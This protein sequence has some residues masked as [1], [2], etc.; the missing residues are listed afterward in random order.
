MSARALA[1][2]MAASMGIELHAPVFGE[3]EALCVALD[4]F[5]EQGRR[6]PLP[7]T[8][9][10]SECRGKLAIVD[11]AGCVRLRKLS[12]GQRRLGWSWAPHVYDPL[13]KCTPAFRGSFGYPRFIEEHGGT[14]ELDA[15]A[16]RGW[17]RAW[18]DGWPRD[19]RYRPA[20]AGVGLCYDPTPQ[21]YNRVVGAIRQRLQS[22]ELVWPDDITRTWIN[23]PPS[24]QMEL[25]KSHR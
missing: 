1:D 16:R 10:F 14:E 7:R 19:T 11:L 22:P 6:V 9:Y 8:L 13:S 18:Y 12:N 20:T 15:I 2:E 5:E 17:P 24:T 23:L 3:W 21:I 25:T 4:R